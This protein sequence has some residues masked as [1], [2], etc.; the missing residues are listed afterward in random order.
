MTR[1][2]E[3]K[4]SLLYTTT[5]AA[6]GHGMQCPIRKATPKK[7]AMMLGLH[8][9]MTQKKTKTERC[10]HEACSAVFHDHETTTKK[11]PLNMECNFQAWDAMSQQRSDDPKP[12]IRLVLQSCS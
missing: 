2:S 4:R 6:I 3:I 5:G 12:A 10:S 11:Q 1:Y 8:F 7:A 9:S